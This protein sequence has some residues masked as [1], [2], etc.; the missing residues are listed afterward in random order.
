MNE[1]YFHSY[2]I[3]HKKRLTAQMRVWR[4]ANKTYVKNWNSQYLSRTKRENPSKYIFSKI[5][6]RAKRE[7]IKFNITQ[8][9]VKV[10]HN[11]PILGIPL[12][13]DLERKNWPSLDR[14]DNN[15]G[16]VKGNV[17]VVSMRANLLKNDASVK[18]LK[19]LYYYL[20]GIKGAE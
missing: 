9:D 5:K 14:I 7:R 6:R 19:M 13:Y 2:Y 16:Y 8:K 18:E 11:C 20:A 15:K 3:R 12:S 10:P 1:D 4:A 17:Q